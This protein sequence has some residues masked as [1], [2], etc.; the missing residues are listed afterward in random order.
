MKKTK[1][2]DFRRQQPD[3]KD[4]KLNGFRGFLIRHCGQK[5][6]LTVE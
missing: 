5:F 3:R 1:Y 6:K 2:F 4:K